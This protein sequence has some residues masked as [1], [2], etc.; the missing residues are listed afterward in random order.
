MT[1]DEAVRETRREKNRA[2]A[3]AHYGKNRVA[4]VPKAWG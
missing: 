4:S 2:Y 1:D 3:K